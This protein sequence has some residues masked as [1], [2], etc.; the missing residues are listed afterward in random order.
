MGA[1]LGG[2]TL[3]LIGPFGLLAPSGV[4]IDVRSRKAVALL[5]LLAMAPDGVRTR[6]WLQTQ[7]WGSRGNVQ[8]QSSL[9]RELAN[10]ARL[11]ARHNAAALLRRDPQRVQLNLDLIQ[12]DVHALAVT[13][14]R[15]DVRNK[16]QFLEGLDLRD[17]DEFEEW[18]REQR[19]HFHDFVM[20]P[21]PSSPAALPGSADILGAAMDDLTYLSQEQKPV[22]PPKPSL[23]VL[24]F[25]VTGNPAKDTWQGE[26]MA[27]QLGLML[28]QFPQLFVVSSAA[29]AALAARGLSPGE[30][31][32]DLGVRY[33]L[34]GSLRIAPE[35][36]RVS[37][38][39]IDGKTSQ[40]I[41]GRAFK[42]AQSDALQL[43]EGIVL[44]VAPQIWTNIDLSERHRGRITPLSDPD[45]YALYWRANAL[46][47]DWRRD[48]TIEA[49]KLTDQLVALNSACA[50]SAALASFCN[51]I[52]Y[53]FGWTE[54]PASARRKAIIQFQ[55][56]V[57][58]GPD[59]VEAIG[60][61]VGTLVLIGGDMRLADEL[62]GHALDLLP[63]YQPNLCWGGLADI[64]MGNNSRARERL[65]LSLRINPASGVRPYALT[66]I[67]LSLMMDG[68]YAKALA[69]LENATLNAPE[70]LLAQAALAVAALYAGEQDKASAAA[71]LTDQMG[72][73][74]AATFILR[75]EVHRE[76]LRRGLAMVP[77]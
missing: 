26:S 67:G 71:R 3:N 53:G 16:G 56:A 52:A 68:Q 44:A 7:L 46:F 13:V 59:N 36:V 61:A 24:P 10:L 31:A 43:E 32:A 29:G 66:G 65:E 57:R 12:I 1:L 38:Q 30:I 34:N 14:D 19:A 8:A 51:A 20:Q 35:G 48:S 21:L 27:E 37:V 2:Y 45:S 63:A 64:A 75:N 4:R 25:S 60:Y 70:L 39:L 62:I 55:N 28:T 22:V 54:D 69:M 74:D 23:V 76:L 40:Q 50:Q 73:A 41:W 77:R 33:V 5:A 72:G 18:L 42:S 11:F 58:L 15:R 6:N 17:C 49:I 9:R 47:R